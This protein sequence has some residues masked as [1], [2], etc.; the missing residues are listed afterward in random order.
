MS[1]FLMFTGRL[2]SECCLEDV[3][4]CP[5]RKNL[6]LSDVFETSQRPPKSLPREHKDRERLYDIFRASQKRP[7]S[8]S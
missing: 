4:R 1:G 8:A 2:L 3:R 7:M 6:D 5:D